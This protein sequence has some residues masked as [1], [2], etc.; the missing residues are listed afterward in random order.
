MN[1]KSEADRILNDI[2]TY[3]RTSA[4]IASRSIAS[5]VFDTQEKAQVFEKLCEGASQAR[6]EAVTGIPKQT[7]SRWIIEFVEAGLVTPPSEY[8]N[9]YRTLFTLRELAI[10]TSELAKRKKK[11]Q[12]E[13]K[14]EKADESEEAIKREVSK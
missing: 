9:N 7:I 1:E 12:V 13:T 11:Q 14:A 6:I 10:N 4:A 8:S 3:L 2:R 5:K